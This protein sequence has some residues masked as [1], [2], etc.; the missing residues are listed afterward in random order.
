M[1]RGEPLLRDRGPRERS[2]LFLALT[3][4]VIL[5]VILIAPDLTAAALAAGLAAS[6]YVLSARPEPARP[7][8]AETKAARGSGGRAEA[9]TTA[10]TAPPGAGA[11]AF[12]R[13]PLTAGRPAERYPGAIDFGRAGHDEAPAL[14]HVDWDAAA[15]DDVPAGNPFDPGRVS[16]PQAAAPCADDDALLALDGDELNVL[17]VR[18]RNDPERVWAGIYRRKALVARYVAEE[19]KMAEQRRWWGNHE[20]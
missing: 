15:R 7:G 1:A 18:S 4:V 13:V 6:L 2:D 9:F 8:P 20:V 11:P 17:Q 12:P 5:I 19:L 14:G 10:T 16:S 3:V